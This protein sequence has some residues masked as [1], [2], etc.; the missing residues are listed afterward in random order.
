VLYKRRAV[1]LT[2]DR[3]YERI[4][5]HREAKLM[6]YH[7]KQSALYEKSVKQKLADEAK[8]ANVA[9]Q[10]RRKQEKLIAMQAKQD[11]LMR[12]RAYNEARKVEKASKK[13]KTHTN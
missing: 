11:D 5:E 7:D 12:K 4:E 1:L 8:V 6:V 9:R 10:A 3:V 13:Y 2:H